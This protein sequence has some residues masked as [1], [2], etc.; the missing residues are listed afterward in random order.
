MRPVVLVEH[1]LAGRGRHTVYAQWNELA[2]FIA[3]NGG[4]E[5]AIQNYAPNQ[6]YALA[7]IGNVGEGQGPDVG[8]MLTSGS[9]VR[10]QGMLT[11]DADWRLTPL[12]GELGPARLALLQTLYQ[13]ATPRAARSWPPTV[14]EAP[15]R[16]GSYSPDASS[17]AQSA[18]RSRIVAT[19]D[20]SPT[21]TAHMTPFPHE[22][23]APGADDRARRPAL[24]AVRDDPDP[25]RALW[26][27]LEAFGRGLR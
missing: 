25:P 12:G 14:G 2:A 6:A 10:I 9:A 16:A 13:P 3:A 7:G 5:A 11:R 1:R 26:A 19:P 22:R 15:E 18:D 27:L 17:H 24:R 20:S 8:S 4:T 23:R 21:S